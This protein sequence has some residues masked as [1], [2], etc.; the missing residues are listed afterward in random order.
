MKREHFWWLWLV[1]CVSWAVQ[2][3]A[4][5]TISTDGDVRAQGFVGDGS[6]VTEVDAQLLDGMDSSDFAQESD[7]ERGGDAGG[8]SGAGG[9]SGAGP[10]ATDGSSDLF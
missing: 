1:V 3:G 8:A 5:T 9:R 6:R 10:G 2:T 4:Q 7:H